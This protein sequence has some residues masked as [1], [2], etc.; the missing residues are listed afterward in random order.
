MKI[1]SL[2]FITI[3]SLFII[4]T[5]CSITGTSEKSKEKINSGSENK[6]PPAYILYNVTHK[7]Y[8]KG[9]L[10]VSVNFSRG[11]YY[12]KEDLLRADGC[13]FEYFEDGE[14][15]TTGRS[16]KA[17]F[18]VS[19]SLLIAKGDV[20]IT[21]VKNKTTLVTD[22]LEWYGDENIFTTDSEVKITRENG[23]SISGKGLT[24]DI[25]LKIIRIK[26]NVRGTIKAR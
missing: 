3:F 20:V 9:K 26:H 8:E 12:S 16:I 21:S 2:F 14:V 17:D 10:V 15:I 11:E 23:D 18:Y 6:N 13:S 1:F 7:H 22:Y 24:A 5:G 19:K 4:F 25:A